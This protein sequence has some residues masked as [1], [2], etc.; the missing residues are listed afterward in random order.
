MYARLPAFIIAFHGCDEETKK[1][2][3]HE[4]HSMYE[5]RNPYDWLGRGIYF[6]EQDPLRALEYARE[7]SAH[8]ERTRGKVSKPAVIGAVIDYGNCLNLMR[9]EDIKMVEQANQYY[10]LSL[11]GEQPAQNKGSGLLLRYRDCTVIETLH[12]LQDKLG[13]LPYDTVRGLFVE[14]DPIYEN[15]G[16]YSKTHIQICVRNPNCIK[17][18][19]DPKEPDASYKTPG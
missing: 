13:M 17:A 7:L 14:G 11:A 15:A 5:S 2:V 3:L 4:G 6:W 1:R 16:F 19:F 10:E 18:V 8:P 12:F 9:R